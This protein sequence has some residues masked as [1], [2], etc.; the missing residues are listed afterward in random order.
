MIP[1]IATPGI[2]A[3][4]HPPRLPEA[5]AALHWG[6]VL[7]GFGLGLLLA[8]GLL[9]LLGP[10]LRRRPRAIRLPERVAATRGLP[11]Q[12]RL[13]ALARILSE[14]GGT[15]PAEQRAALYSGTADPEALE[16][17]ILRGARG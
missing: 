16:R 17:L 11:A 14:T 9:I 6:D 4:L 2:V 10:M 1:E 7:A 13:L 12:D 8:W 15:L 5:F 3:Q